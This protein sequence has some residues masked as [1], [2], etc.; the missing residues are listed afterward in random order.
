MDE[1]VASS[2]G[3]LS[4]LRTTWVWPG[5]AE[6]GR[7]IGTHLISGMVP[8]F[9]IAGAIAVFLDKA[10]ITRLMG[11]K[12]NPL[13]SF[14]VAAFSGGLLT[15]CSCGVIPIFTGIMTRGA[16]S[17]PAFTF[18]FAAPAINLIAL[19]YTLSLMG[20]E[21]ALGRV[22]FVMVCAVFIGLGIRLLFA[23]PPEVPADMISYADDDN[24]RTD[25]Q[26][27]VFFG[28][29]VFL[30]LTSTGYFDIWIQGKT[31]SAFEG[32]LTGLQGTPLQRLLPKLFMLLFEAGIIFIM[33]KQWF[34]PDEAKQWLAK[35]WSLFVMIF[36]K[37]LL[38]IFLSGL[39]AA[40]FPLSRF[41]VYFDDN[42]VRANLLVSII[43]AMS[44]FGTIVGVNVVATMTHFGMHSGPAMAFL[45][46]GPS[47]SLP[48]ILALLPIIGRRKAVVYFF[49]VAVSTT[50]SG[51]LFGML[52]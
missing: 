4:Y 31:L 47:V 43:G 11:A 27:A 22:V 25:F 44:Y 26:M 24:P 16:G 15:V 45:L 35:A 5:I 29:L 10:R 33:L 7:F 28:M 48:E 51:L 46:S 23:D 12:A 9:L 37:V 34:R 21:F 41:M 2:T 13:I 39:L 17:G 18:L 1:L 42:S 36:P 20:L 19:T 49:L 6:V 3:F 14:P 8:A 40:A 50:I 30:M 38:G 52:F 32:G